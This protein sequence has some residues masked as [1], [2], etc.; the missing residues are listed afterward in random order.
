M[1]DSNCRIPQDGLSCPLGKRPALEDTTGFTVGRAEYFCGREGRQT[2]TAQGEPVCLERVGLTLRKEVYPVHVPVGEGVLIVLEL[3]NSSTL[4]L[5]NLMLYDPDVC[6]WQVEALSLDGLPLSGDLASGLPL[7][8]V[9]PGGSLRIT[10]SARS[11]TAPS[12][13]SGAALA[14]AQADTPQGPVTLRAS[15]QTRPP[16]VPSLRVETQIDRPFVSLE[17]PI[18]AL[19]LRGINQG[20]LPLDPVILTH[21]LPK[22]LKYVPGSTSVRGAPC[23]DLDPG[24]GISLGPL[25]PGETGTVRFLARWVHVPSDPED[26]QPI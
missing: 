18:A 22:G 19:T 8:E 17:R 21:T 4:P 15:S 1:C 5:R 20:D 23:M 26:P 2:F 9:G 6:V 10:V 7:P 16:L 13:P 3:K 12:L 11:E 25:A 14:E 24:L